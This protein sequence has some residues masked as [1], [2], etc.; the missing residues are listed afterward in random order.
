MSAK[1]YGVM[2]EFSTP[3]A[4]LDAAHAAAAAGYR[5]IEAYTPFAVDGLAE[6]IGFTQ[7]R[8]PLLTLCGGIVG[9]LGAHFLQWYTAV[10][11]Y[12]VNAGGRP[13]NAWPAFVPGIFELTILGAALAAFFGFLILNGLPAFYH[14]VFNAPDF[15]LATRDR[16]FLCLR[17]ADTF[18]VGAAQEWL[19]GRQSVRVVTVDE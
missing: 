19:Q 7:T 10:F 15:D 2:A 13:L 6:A 3:E 16:F 17:T 18:D 8:L 4:L 1:A 12:P 14:P 5:R 11:D 9:G